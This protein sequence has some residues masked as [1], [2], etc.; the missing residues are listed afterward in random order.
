MSSR[1]V[2]GSRVLITGGS[3]LLG[4]ALTRALLDRGVAVRV[5]DLTDPPT[6]QENV[7]FVR[8]DVSHARDVSD[9]CRDCSAVFHLAGRMPQARLSEE[10]FRTVNVDGTRH[11]AEGC[12]RFGVPTL[13]F[14]S[15]IEM[16]GPQKNF[17]IREDAPKLFSGVYSRN[18][19]ECERMLRKFRSRHGLR[20]SMLRMPMILGTG[21]Y[22]EKSV[23]E[24]M[25]RVRRDRPLPLP[26]GPEVPFTAVAATDAARAF[27][28]A[29]EREEA[30]GEAFNIT[31]GRGEPSR[32]FFTR[33][34]RAVGSRSRVI[35]VPRWI[36]VPGI[37]LA[38]KLNRPL[39]LVDT[40]AELLP[41]ALTGGDYDITKAMER[42]GYQPRTDCLTALVEMYHDL[43]QRDE[44]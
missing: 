41:F 44:I 15:T 2:P 40:P 18:K 5:F 8:G 7:E 25:R 35:P 24:M 30:D 23:L 33:F 13:V 31:S 42:L 1:L 19:W 17:P 34:A 38:V 12:I 16:Y 26:G 10:G 29:A 9:A 28:L 27:L 20:V 14:A 39:P 6:E 21:F 32:A 36:V 4:R 3:G 11:A 43:S 37:A 22:H